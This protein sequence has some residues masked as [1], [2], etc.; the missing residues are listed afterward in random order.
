[1]DI[2]FILSFVGI[3]IFNLSYGENEGYLMIM[4]MRQIYAV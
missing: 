1:M 2:L 3:G 4:Y